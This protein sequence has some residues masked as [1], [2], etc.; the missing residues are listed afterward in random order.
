MKKPHPLYWVGPLLEKPTAHDEDLLRQLRAHGVIDAFKNGK[1][2]IHYGFG[3]ASCED[4]RHWHPERLK[5]EAGKLAMCQVVSGL[6]RHDRHCDHWTESTS[7][8]R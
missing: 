6:V 8:K 2:D 3:E 4:C 7:A 1:Y 5:Q